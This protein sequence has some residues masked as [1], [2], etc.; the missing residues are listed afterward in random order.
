MVKQYRGNHKVKHF[1][2]AEHFRIMA[3]AQFTHR[4][5]HFQSRPVMRFCEEG[6]NRKRCPMR[7]RSLFVVC[8]MRSKLNWPRK[9]TKRP[10]KTRS[11]TVSITSSWLSTVSVF[12]PN[13]CRLKARTG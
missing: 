8:A 3:F 7:P 12:S 4:R 5:R 11:I 9:S 13:A 6:P 1:S 2:C 10:P